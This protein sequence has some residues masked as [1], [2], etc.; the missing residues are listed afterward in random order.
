MRVVDEE[1]LRGEVGLFVS[2]EARA[3]RITL[4]PDSWVQGFDADFSRKLGDR[5]WLGMTWPAEFG[6]HERSALERFV[7]IEELLAAGAPVSAHWIADR[8]TG[9]LFL[10][11]GTEEQRRRFLPEIAAGRLFVSAGLSEPDTGSDLASVRT[12]AVPASGGWCVNGR[13]IWTTNAH[14]NH[15][16]LTLLRTSQGG[17]RHEGLSQMFIPLDAPGVGVRAIETMGGESHFAEVTFD[18]VFVPHADVVGEVGG[19]WQQVTSELSYERSGPE[20][21]LSSFPLL[22]AM[23]AE[24]DLCTAVAAEVGVLTARLWALRCL[25]VRVQRL[26]D[27]HVDVTTQAAL[28]KDCGNRLEREIVQLCHRVISA[29]AEPPSPR[30][31]SYLRRA[32]LAAP[33]FSLRGGTV[34]ILRGI[35]AKGLA[36]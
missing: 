32:L 19:G 24:L 25:S 16:I 28:V 3:G 36:G 22:A 10:R 2:D 6:G 20:R 14:R 12:K 8:Q 18:D 26:L 29:E 34:E 13:K 15:W 27:E 21:Y 23:L 17:G 30:L 1:A 11:F 33:T 4:M 31:A 5:G 7:V 35:V 9:P